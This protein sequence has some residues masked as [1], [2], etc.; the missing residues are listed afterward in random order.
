MSLGIN[1]IDYITLKEIYAWNGLLENIIG[2]K[3]FLY[4]GTKTFNLKMAS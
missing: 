3:I 1:K 4:P 2:I